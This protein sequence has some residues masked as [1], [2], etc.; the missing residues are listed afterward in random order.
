M[1]HRRKICVITGSRAEYGLFYW[2]LKEIQGDAAF[3]LQLVVTGTHLLQTFG[4]TVDEIEKNGFSINCKIEMPLLETEDAPQGVTRAV[5]KAVCGF[6]DAFASLKPDFVVLLGDRFETTA[7]AFAAAIARIPI[8]HIHGGETT[9]GAFDESFRHA[10]T[11]MSFLHFASAEPYRARIVQMGESPDRVFCVGALGLDHLE[12]TTPLDRR[13]LE[14]SLDCSLSYPTF[15]VT[16]HPVTLEDRTSRLDVQKL[17]AGLDAFPDAKIIFTGANADPDNFIIKELIQ[18]YVRIKNGRVKFFASLG[19]LRY[20]SLLQQADVV[21]G[22]SSSGIIEAPSFKKPTVNIGDRQKG[23]LMAHSIINCRSE[24][25]EIIQAIQKALSPSFQQKLKEV[26]NPHGSGDSARKI[27]DIL[28][29]YPLDEGM[30][31]KEFYDLPSL[32]TV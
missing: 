26:A 20:L 16:Y 12:R 29:S 17:L 14:R 23:R 15:L 8:A 25:G 11:K 9:A 4:H 31:K 28:K 10:I 22:N 21:I 27:A 6:A 1:T 13:E 19:Y 24:T 30:L 18:S 2:L 7:A 3:H 32:F 5:G